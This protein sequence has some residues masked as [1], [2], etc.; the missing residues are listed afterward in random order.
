MELF[1]ECINSS[2]TFLEPRSTAHPT[3]SCQLRSPATREVPELKDQL[4]EQGLE[5]ERVERENRALRKAP[6]AA[7]GSAAPVAEANSLRVHP[8]NSMI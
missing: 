3:G 7:R 2:E 6:R 1:D 8:G 4:R 5:L